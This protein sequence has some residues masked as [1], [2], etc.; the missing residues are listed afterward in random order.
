MENKTPTP[1]D[2]QFKSI[3]LVGRADK[4]SVPE[5]LFSI[6]NYLQSHFKLDL[7]VESLTAENTPNHGLPVLHAD[8]LKD[9]VDL[10]I[11]IGGDGSLINAAHIAAQHSLPVLGINRGRLGFLTDIAPNELEKVGDV[12]RGHFQLEHRGLLKAKLRH[13]KRPIAQSLA[14]NDVV[15]LPTDIAH[16]IEFE[17]YINREF[18]CKHRADGLIAATPTGST[19]YALSGGGS[20]MHPQLDA[21][22]LVPMF[23][24]NLSSR[25]IVVQNS[26]KIE[27]KISEDNQDTP[28]VSTDGQ[29]RIPIPPGGTVEI[30]A[31]S[32]SL[33]LIHPQDYN[34]YTTLREKLGWEN[35]I[36]K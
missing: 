35:S 7:Y 28:F 18:V 21:I 8:E 3:V 13:G 14:L 12:L 22:M 33:Q 15:L 10:I 17:I 26:S 16:M 1:S 11:V 2:T 24:H 34:Y 32:Q 31:Y 5:T 9:K 36:L 19:A 4:S 25:P 29:A 30:E 23:P 20:I 27:L 6:R